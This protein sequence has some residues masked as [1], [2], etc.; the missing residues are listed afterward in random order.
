MKRVPLL[1]F[2]VVGA[3]LSVLALGACSGP[4]MPSG[5]AG[6]GN[7]TVQN[8]GGS[9][10]TGTG[11][12]YSTGGSYGTGGFYGTGG[13]TGGNTREVEDGGQEGERRGDGGRKRG[14]NGGTG[15]SGGVGAV[16]PPGTAAGAPCMV[17]GLTCKASSG[18]GGAEE[19]CSCKARGG[20]PG[21]WTCEQ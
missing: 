8:T 1:A 13:S 2:L 15:G 9:Y 20:R 5:D 21:M 17:G 16:C 6:Y 12:Y 18:D 11:G 10:V 4:T 19:I 7:T 3:G 14:D